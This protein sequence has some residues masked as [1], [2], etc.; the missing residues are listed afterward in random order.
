MINEKDKKEFKGIRAPETLKARILEDCE[1]V[2][3]AEKNYTRKYI[4]II[5]ACLLVVF[6][7]SFFGVGLYSAPV[8]VNGD[9]H[10]GKELSL[11]SYEPSLA[12]QRGYNKNQLIEVDANF[13][14]EISL[15]GGEFTLLDS[16]TGEEIYSGNKHSVKSKV[17]I[18]INSID[19]EEAVLNIQNIFSGKEIILKNNSF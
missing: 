17:I 18:Q 11:N 8:Y 16:R 10:F 2:T 4:Q 9:M 14:T 12:M 7:A 6:T 3:V 1:N 13:E 5:A 15:I 19:G